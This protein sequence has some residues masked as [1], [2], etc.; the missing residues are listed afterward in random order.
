MDAHKAN[1]KRAVFDPAGDL[2]YSGGDDKCLR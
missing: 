1:I 2:I